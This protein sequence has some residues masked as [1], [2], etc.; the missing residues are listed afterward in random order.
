MGL[1]FLAIKGKKASSLLN[2]LYAK[3]VNA[4]HGSF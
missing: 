1:F 3:G 4:N 2:F